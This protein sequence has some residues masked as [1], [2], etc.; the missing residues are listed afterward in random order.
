MNAL[1]SGGVVQLPAVV[2]QESVK[3]A[4]DYRISKDHNP[5]IWLMKL[6]EKSVW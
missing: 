3:S 4:G 2:A 1:L 5:Y 6:V